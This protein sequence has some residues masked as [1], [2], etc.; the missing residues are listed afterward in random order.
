MINLLDIGAKRDLKAARMNVVLA[1]YIGVVGMAL[2]TLVVLVLFSHWWLGNRIASAE[3][4][5]VANKAQTRSYDSVRSQ[6]AAFTSNLSKIQSVLSS[7]S[8]FNTAL[9]NIAASL[10]AGSHINAVTLSPAFATTPLT[11]NAS[12][13]TNEA[14]LTLKETLS[15]SKF[16]S[17]VS[18]DNVNCGSQNGSLC[19]VALTATINQ[20]TIFDPGVNP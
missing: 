9:L 11:I 2:L 16:F 15:K 14:A 8:H 1:T 6:A 7:R 4:K 20:A 13:P 10:P 12:T 3:A 18:L 5:Q 17:S 19:A